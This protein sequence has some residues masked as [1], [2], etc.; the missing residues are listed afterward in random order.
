MA[1]IT[2]QVPSVTGA[3]LSMGSAANGDTCK[4]GD[5]YWLL[6]QNTDGSPHDVTVVVPGTGAYGVAN[7]DK[8]YTIAA[9]AIV[10]IPMLAAAV[11]P[12]DRLVHLTWSALTGMK[13]AL[14][15]Y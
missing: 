1:E 13:R 7:G 9:G 14:T 3:A 11:D 15:K 5:G 8:T 10:P 12:A 6:V 2:P 4:G